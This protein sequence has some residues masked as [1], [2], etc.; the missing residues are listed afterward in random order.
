MN[1]E[2]L[3]LAWLGRSSNG[4]RR[5]RRQV[6][7]VLRGGM[8]LAFAG[9]GLARSWVSHSLA[10]VLLSVSLRQGD[11]ALCLFPSRRHRHGPLNLIKIGLCTVYLYLYLCLAA[12]AS[13][14]PFFFFFLWFLLSPFGFGLPRAEFFFF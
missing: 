3:K 14:F 7:L 1:C 13:H 10:L 6:D 4:N 9:V 8:G 12:L 5:R 2:G 11:T